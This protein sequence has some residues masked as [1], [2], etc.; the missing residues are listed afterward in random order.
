MI[1]NNRSI[2]YKRTV[3]RADSRRKTVEGN[4]PI[5]YTQS[6]VYQE[7]DDIKDRTYTF[8]KYVF[9]DTIYGIRKDFEGIFLLVVGQSLKGG[10]EY[11]AV[12]NI[13]GAPRIVYHNISDGNGV[14]KPYT[15]EDWPGVGRY[16]MQY[17]TEL[18]K[19]FLIS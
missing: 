2:R 14:F 5:L 1:T 10:K 15:V 4:I 18:Q 11:V 3:N 12:D 6:A 13:Y 19:L 17:D 9:G 8:Y 7:E 16:I